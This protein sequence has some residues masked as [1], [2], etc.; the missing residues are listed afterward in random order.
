MYLDEKRDWVPPE[1]PE[2]PARR[3]TEKQESLLMWIMMANLL[4]L[5]V[6][7]IA[8]VTLFGALFALLGG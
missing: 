2:K 5:F 1:W 8:G 4:L 6:A 7:P 3:L